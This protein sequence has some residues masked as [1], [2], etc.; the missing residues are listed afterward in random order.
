M[1]G[2]AIRRNLLSTHMEYLEKLPKQCLES[3]QRPKYAGGETEGSITVLCIGKE[4]VQDELGDLPSLAVVVVWK[5]LY[6]Y[7]LPQTHLIV[8]VWYIAI[9]WQAIQ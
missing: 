1:R 5:V 7:Q 3:A 6:C 8:T 2:S 9:L 4:T